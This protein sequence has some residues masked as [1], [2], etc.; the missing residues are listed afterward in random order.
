MTN[1]FCC[2]I[3]FLRLEG[4]GGQKYVF[5]TIICTCIKER[6]YFLVITFSKIVYVLKETWRNEVI[7]SFI[8]ISF[9][10][11]VININ[12]KCIIETIWCRLINEQC[13]LDICH[14]IKDNW[15]FIYFEI[16]FESTLSNCQKNYNH[17][18]YFFYWI[19]AKY[20]LKIT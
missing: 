9:F 20:K 10:K 8:A 15:L 5:Y 17:I 14:S 6:Q 2:S 12:R 3:Y 4:E 16:N 7:N 18:M 19:N 13:F 11:K 1:I